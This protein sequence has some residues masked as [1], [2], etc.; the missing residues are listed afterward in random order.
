MGKRTLILVLAMIGACQEEPAEEPMRPADFTAHPGVETVTVTGAEAGAELTLYDPEGEPLVTVVADELGTAHFS[1]IPGEHQI[2]D[3]NDPD[4]LSL[5]SGDVLPPGDGY[6]IQDDTTDPPAW[7]QPFDV[8]AVDDVASEE[9]YASQTLTGLHWSPLTGPDG[10]P[11]SGYQYIE[12]RDGVK[13]GAMVR[14]PDKALYGEGPHPTVVEYSGYSP[15]RPDR[16]DNG[17]FIANALGFATVS[18]NMR[19]SGCSG[20]VFDVFNRAQAA[21]GY[22]I[23]EVVAA[24]EWVLNGMVGMVGLSYPGVSQLYVGATNPPHLGA[25]VPLSVI[26][27]AWEMQWPGGIYNVGFTRSWVEERE[28]QAQVGGQGWVSDRIAAG[29]AQCEEN[30]AISH[31]SVDF[32]TFLRSLKMRPASSDDRDLRL[33]VEQI[34][35]PVF[36]GGQFQDEQTGPQ[37]GEMLDRFY[38][39]EDLRVLIG[40]GRHV[41]GYAPHAVERWFEFL[42]FHV[43]GRIPVLNPLIRQFGAGEFGGEFG[44]TDVSFGPD[45]FTGFDS[46]DEAL[47]AYMAEPDVT[48]LFENGGDVERPG[49][50]GG[51]WSVELPV[52]PPPV[53]DDLRWF[54]GPEGELAEEAPSV[55]ASDAWAFDPEAGSSTFFGPRGYE[56]MPPLWDVDWTVFE[57]GHM[58]S[59]LTAPFEEDVVLTGPGIAELWLKSSVSEMDVQVTLTEVRPDGQE[60]Y[61]QSGWLR[62]GHRASEVGDDHRILRTYA[63]AD[64]EPMPIGEWVSARVQVHSVAHPVREGS[65]LRVIVSTPGRDHGTWEFEPPAYEAGEAPTFELGVGGAHASSLFMSAL[66]GIDIPE[67]LPDC[68]GLRGQVCRPYAFVM[69]VAAE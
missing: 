35:A 66:P 58:A 56:L 18:V 61:I 65:Q 16:P 47:Q 13:L 68:D 26:A 32:E 4:P 36:F 38:M 53:Q 69:N 44:M 12:M 1:Y 50:P 63:E 42:E 54:L 25:I 30:L 28:S 27:D 39:S 67:E 17:S 15:S 64:H 22:D 10:D 14:F 21:D 33:L 6:V 5:A 59:Y 48:L 60:L 46:F 52:W 23:I 43:A 3:L 24:Q 2:L 8:L 9:F 62:L 57:Q 41:D 45:R 49:E 37:F 51:R 20:G 55:D 29:D 11:E 34:E 31:H 19:G 40:N 7:S